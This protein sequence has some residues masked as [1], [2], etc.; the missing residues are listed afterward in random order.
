L[1]ASLTQNTDQDGIGWCNIGDTGVAGYAGY[2]AVTSST[3]VGLLVLNSASTYAAGNN[4]NNTRPHT[5]GN[6]DTMIFEFTTR[7]A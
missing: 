5:F 6:T 2:I 4:V 3:Q 1:P 7:L